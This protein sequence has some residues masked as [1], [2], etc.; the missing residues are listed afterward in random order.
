M[1]FL[2]R[3]YELSFQ[4]YFIVLKSCRNTPLSWEIMILKGSS[5]SLKGSSSSNVMVLLLIRKKVKKNKKIAFFEDQTIYPFTFCNK[6]CKIL[7]H[8]TCLQV[9]AKV[10]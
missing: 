1:F 8:V 6:Q 10:T 7:V 2:L 4:K 3:I 5:S 9:H